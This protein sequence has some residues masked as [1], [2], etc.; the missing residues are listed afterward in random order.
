VL[1]HWVLGIHRIRVD[2]PE[3]LAY[4]LG[5][6]AL[7]GLV[8]LAL[9][10]LLLRR[11]E[12]GGKARRSAALL[13]L[14]ALFAAPIASLPPPGSRTALV[15]FAPEQ[16]ST[17][18]FVAAHRAGTPVL[19]MNAAGTVAAV[20][21]TSPGARAALYRGGARVVTRS[22]ALAGCLAALKA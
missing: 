1:F 15:L 20:D 9:G 14:T 17:N 12:G 21:L 8:P 7:L 10:W 3:P 2:V 16:G 4:D 19:W 22:P 18:A 5:W 13:G 11:G 6:L